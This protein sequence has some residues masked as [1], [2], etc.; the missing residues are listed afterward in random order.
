MNGRAI[1]ILFLKDLFLSRKYLFA[2]FVAGML[3]AI[4]ACIPDETVAF[5]GYY[6]HDDRRHGLEF[7]SSELCCSEKLSTRHARLC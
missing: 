5:V 4:L 1:Q 7:T 3:S 2:Y 6:P